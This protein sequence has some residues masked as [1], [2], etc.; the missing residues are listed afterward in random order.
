MFASAGGTNPAAPPLSGH[1][2]GA[3]GALVVPPDAWMTHD[4]GAAS[5]NSQNNARTLASSICARRAR[6]AA[7]SPDVDWVI[8]RA[9]ARKAFRGNAALIRTRQSAIGRRSGRL[10]RMSEARIR[11]AMRRIAVMRGVNR[12]CNRPNRPQLRDLYAYS[13]ASTESLDS[14]R[15][16]LARS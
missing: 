10:G 3:P 13:A 7:E 9:P 11:R 12:D 16:G 5:T 6:F 1:L 2:T 14:T 8:Q 4:W 15:L